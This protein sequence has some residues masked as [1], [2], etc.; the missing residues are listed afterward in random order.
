M[1]DR[2]WLDGLG[3]LRGVSSFKAVLSE[4]VGMERVLSRVSSSKGQESAGR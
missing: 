2:A 1:D 4:R 3:L